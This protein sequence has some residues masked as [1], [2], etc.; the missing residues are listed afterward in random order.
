MIRFIMICLAGVAFGGAAVAQ[1]SIGN[2]VVR[3]GGAVIDADG[4][5]TGTADV[6]RGGIRSRGGAT[7]IRTNGNRRR[8]A[9]GGGALAV[10]GNGNILDVEDCRRL[11]LDGNGNI[12]SAH[13][14]GNGRAAVMGNRNRLTWSAAPG[15]KVAVSN[16]GSGNVV[17]QR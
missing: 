16:P 12:V 3:S 4:I 13:F 8:V 1:V 9:C 7:T 6:G 11:T 2:G 14:A 10:E 17:S 15:A 5:H